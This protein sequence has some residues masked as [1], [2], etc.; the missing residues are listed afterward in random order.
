MGGSQDEAEG[1]EGSYPT[2]TP[3]ALEARGTRALGDV[4]GCWAG[5]QSLAIELHDRFDLYFGKPPLS[6]A[7]VAHA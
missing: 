7:P 3:C 2:E 6:Q 5:T 4:A 1:G